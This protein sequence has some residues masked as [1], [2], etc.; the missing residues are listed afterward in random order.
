MAAT[1]L[2]NAVHLCVDMQRLFC[3]PTEW[4]TPWME[5][6]LPN[7]VRLVEARPGRTA[8]T[9]FIPLNNASQGWGTWRSYYHRYEAMTLE[10]L[11]P[12]LI[13]LHEA[14]ASF[15][16]PALVFDKHVYSPWW[17]PSLHTRLQQDHVSTLLLTGGETEICVLA[18][19]LGAIDLG[20]RV[21]V[22]SDGVF[23]SADPTHDAMLYIY[24]SRFGTQM[25]M[26]T[27]DEILPLWRAAGE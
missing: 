10:R 2:A 19:L 16:P 12:D 9:R 20:Y 23:S 11:R 15:T 6:I 25:E 26:A 8:F 4:Q 3:E 7:V 18:T 14:L 27:S 13:E 1:G 24:R 22:I 5:R 17:S 21:I